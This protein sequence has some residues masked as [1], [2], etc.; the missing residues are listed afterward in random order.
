MPNVDDHG[1]EVLKK[2]ARNIHPIP[3]KDYALQVILVGN[4]STAQGVYSPTIQNFPIALKDVVNELTLPINYKAFVLKSRKVSRLK[5]SYESGGPWV[6][7]P[8]GGVYVENKRLDTNK[9]FIESSIDDNIIEVVS[10]S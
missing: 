6:T 3:K 4:E 9:I 7:I 5:I 8:K 10:Y 1:L 2:A